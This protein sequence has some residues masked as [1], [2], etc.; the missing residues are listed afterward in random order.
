MT[1]LA[2]VFNNQQGCFHDEICMLN[3]DGELHRC[4]HALHALLRC[5]ATHHVVKRCHRDVAAGCFAASR[6]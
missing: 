3:H 6:R 1:W 4:L 2:I 5:V